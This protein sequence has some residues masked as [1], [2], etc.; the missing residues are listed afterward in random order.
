MVWFTSGN[1]KVRMKKWWSLTLLPLQMQR[2]M[3]KGSTK[4]YYIIPL[5]ISI[6][7]PTIK[8]IYKK[9]GYIIKDSHHPEHI[10]ISLLPLGKRYRILRTIISRLINYHQ[11]LEPFCITL[12]KTLPQNQT[13]MDFVEG[14]FMYF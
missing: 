12:A 1:W 3:L 14:H 9:A 10:L 5:L 13:S 8:E 6:N 11:A 7:L 4:F 2:F